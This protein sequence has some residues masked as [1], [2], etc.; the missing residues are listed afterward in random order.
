MNIAIKLVAV[1]HNLSRN[2]TLLRGPLLGLRGPGPEF[3]SQKR[4]PASD[5]GV[6]GMDGMRQAGGFEVFDL[7]AGVF[8]VFIPRNI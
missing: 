3:C 1:S 7:V 6:S 5:I 4:P 8:R 2:P